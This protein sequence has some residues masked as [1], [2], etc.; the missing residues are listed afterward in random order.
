MKR[1]SD[2]QI[3]KIAIEFANVLKEWL[4]PEQITEVIK[5]N[6]IPENKTCCATHDFCD[7]NMAMDEAFTK[8]MGREFVFYNDELPESEKQNGID[9][10]AFNT[11]W[12]IAKGNNFYTSKI[13]DHVFR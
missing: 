5:V 4:T 9:T 11:A 13:Y 8:V 12:D 3:N 1:I 7:S 2:S 6:S 10:N